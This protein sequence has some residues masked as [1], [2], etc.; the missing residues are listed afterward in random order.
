M[1]PA[2][3]IAL[4]LT[5]IARP[6]AVFLILGG[7]R[8]SWR[9]CLLVSW[10]G[11]RGASSIVFAIMATVSPAYTRMDVYH[12]VFCIV[13]LSIAIQGTLLPGLARKLGMINEGEDVLKTFSDYKDLP[14]IEMI[15]LEIQ[16]DHPWIGRQVKDLE[17]PSDLLLAMIQ[18]GGRRLIPKGETRI[19]LDDQIVALA[20][21]CDQKLMPIQLVEIAVDRTHPWCGRLIRELKLDAGL[22]IMM[23]QRG[24]SRI[25]PDGSTRIEAEDILVINQPLRTRL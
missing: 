21:T 4:F 5:F 6:A 17:L 14:D 10:A 3:L 19:E 22:L 9:Q 25:V 23:I 24:K 15:Q 2:V 16:A 12:M 8:S 11:L 18:R 1:G 13:L 7:F 20:K